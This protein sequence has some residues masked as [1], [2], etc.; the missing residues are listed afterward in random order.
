MI[1]LEMFNNLKNQTIFDLVDTKGKTSANSNCFS[2]LT[3]KL[4]FKSGD[5]PMRAHLLSS[6]SVSANMNLYK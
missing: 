3:T 4:I 1:L 5:H 2:G 6:A